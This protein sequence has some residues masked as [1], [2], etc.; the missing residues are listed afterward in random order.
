MVILSLLSYPWPGFLK[1]NDKCVFSKLYASS[2]VFFRLQH[3][4]L[5]SPE[6]DSEKWIQVVAKLLDRI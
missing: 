5:G 4:W 3:L 6:L 2:P 1:E